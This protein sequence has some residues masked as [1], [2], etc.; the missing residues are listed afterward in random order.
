MEK[1][2]ESLKKV[3]L[4]L[5]KY[6]KNKTLVPPEDLAGK[7]RVPF[8]NLKAQLADEIS[9]YLI[10]YCLEELQFI[11]DT[12]GWLEEFASAVNRIFK[13][14]GM[15]RKVG[16]AAFLDFDIEKIKQIAEE[17]RIRIYSEA[18]EP[19]FQKH[20]CLYATEEC[21]SENNPQIPRIYNSLVDK[22]WNDNT[23]EWNSGIESGKPA[24]LIYIQGKGKEKQHE[25]E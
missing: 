18:W 23:G 8:Q 9:K 1:S 13:D 20:I 14:S 19:Y 22:F 16:R 15:G 10:A 12:N 17:L 3:C 7:Y 2:E 21:F 24:V 11:P 5:E 6:R 4:T 25:Q